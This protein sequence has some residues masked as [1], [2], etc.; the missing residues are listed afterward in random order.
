VGFCPGWPCWGGTGGAV[1]L[2][3]LAHARR[4]RRRHQPTHGQHP[5]P[6]Q[7][8]RRRCARAEASTPGALRQRHHDTADFKANVALAAIKGQQTVNELAT[9]NG[10]HPHQVLPWKKPALEA[11]PDVFSSRRARTAQDDEALHARLYQ[12]IGQLKVELDWL[13]TKVG[14]ST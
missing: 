11:L 4:Q 12:Q 2:T 3:R 1:V 7:P 9:I 13:K 6:R 8:P 10:V 14:W 5:E